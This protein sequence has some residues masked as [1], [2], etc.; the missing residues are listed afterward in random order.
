M[1]GNE[2]EL[3]MLHTSRCHS[4]FSMQSKCVVSPRGVPGDAAAAE[5]AGDLVL[6]GPLAQVHHVRSL[7]DPHHS[8][9]RAGGQHQAH[10]FRGKLHISH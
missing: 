7:V 5:L 4:S 6:Q 3:Y 9:R 2:E 10:V 8:V 1:T